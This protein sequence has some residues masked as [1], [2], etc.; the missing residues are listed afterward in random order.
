MICPSFNTIMGS[1]PTYCPL[2]TKMMLQ[3]C[4]PFQHN[5]SSSVPSRFCLPSRMTNTTWQTCK[6]LSFTPK[7]LP[8]IA[9]TRCNIN[10]H[11]FLESIVLLWPT[12]LRKVCP[13][14]TSNYTHATC[15]SAN[16]F[17]NGPSLDANSNHTCLH[18]EQPI[19]AVAS[20][21]FTCQNWTHYHDPS[22]TWPK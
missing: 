4:W 21:R 18:S 7:G 3:M 14:M 12:P 15:L 1:Y 20:S 8:D 22:I 11:D 19:I 9:L 16:F 6:Q 13:I 17:G 5:A 2:T 10:R